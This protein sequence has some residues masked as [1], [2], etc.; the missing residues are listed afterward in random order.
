MK[1]YV[2]GFI[3]LLLGIFFFLLY[4]F[5]LAFGWSAGEAGYFDPVVGMWLPNVA[6]GGAGIFLLVRNAKEKPVHLPVW[7]VRS[8]SL[9]IQKLRRK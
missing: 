4:Y 2:V 7:L 6:M 9:L 5:L 8:A 1:Q 3:V